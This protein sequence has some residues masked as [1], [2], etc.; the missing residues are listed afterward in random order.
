MKVLLV[1]ATMLLGAAMPVSAQTQVFV[2]GD[3]FADLKRFSKNT[4]VTTLDGNAVGGG[5]SVG[6]VAADHWRVA[7]EVEPSASTTR[8]RPIL[9]GVLARPNIP[10]TQFQSRRIG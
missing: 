8:T 9:I 5:G 2:S 3:V 10:V 1:A 6:V 7:L 4:S